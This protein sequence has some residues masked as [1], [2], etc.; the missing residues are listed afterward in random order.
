MGIG[1]GIASIYGRVPDYC[2]L[3]L[4]VII[5]VLSCLAL[6]LVLIKVHFLVSLFERSFEE[7]IF[8][9]GSILFM[10]GNVYS[11]FWEVLHTINMWRNYVWRATQL[12]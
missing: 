11:L 3:I 4:S 6:L 2:P 12:I 5:F 9:L 8:I 7:Q 1:L 10:I